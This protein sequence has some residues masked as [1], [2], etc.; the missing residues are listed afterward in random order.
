M[1]AI[2]AMWIASQMRPHPVSG[3]CQARGVSETWGASPISNRR[4][5]TP[6]ARRRR[7]AES[8]ADGP[9]LRRVR[10]LAHRWMA[11]DAGQQN[12]AGGVGGRLEVLLQVAAVEVHQ[13]LGPP[14]IEREL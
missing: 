13:V 4:S 12:P 2:L 3:N 5:R 10:P 1:A 8:M 7:A 9:S 14:R 11:I 6:R